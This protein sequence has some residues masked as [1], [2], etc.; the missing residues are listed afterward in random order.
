MSCKL[1]QYRYY[2]KLNETIDKKQ[3]GKEVVGPILMQDGTKF[4]GELMNGV[5]NG[6][7]KQVWPDHSLYEGYW[8]NDKANAKGRMIHPN[9]E[10]Y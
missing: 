2:F 6:Q 9:G 8:S 7:G 5:R 10:Y 4:I 3:N 1:G